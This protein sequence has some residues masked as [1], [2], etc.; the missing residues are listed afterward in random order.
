M[1]QEAK[2]DWIQLELMPLP[3][4][5]NRFS[6]LLLWWNPDSREIVGEG[7]ESIIDIVNEA[8]S[9]GVIPAKESVGLPAVELVDPLARPSELAAV[10]TQY[11]W[12]IPTPVETKAVKPLQSSSSSLQ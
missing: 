4:H 12:V 7:A 1:S 11:F 8:L 6:E 5:A 10:L 2:I 3:N 9:K